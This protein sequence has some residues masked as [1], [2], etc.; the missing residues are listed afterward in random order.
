MYW[1]ERRAEDKFHLHIMPPELLPSRVDTFKATDKQI[2]T[3]AIEADGL[4]FL[5]EHSFQE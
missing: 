5:A 3:G 2:R 4:F 1:A